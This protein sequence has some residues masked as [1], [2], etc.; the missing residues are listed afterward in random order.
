MSYNRVAPAGLIAVGFQ[1]A[2]LSNS[3]AVPLNSTLSPATVIVFSVEGAD[4][5]V[6]W[7]GSDPTRTTGVLYQA[8]T[9][10]TIEGASGA[11]FQRSTGTVTVSI[12]GFKRPGE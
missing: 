9:V 12:A 10:H 4:V 8:D 2:S 3:T 6:R 1:K 5:R 7:D 11:V